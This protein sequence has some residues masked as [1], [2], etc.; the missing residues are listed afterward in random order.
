MKNVNWFEILKKPMLVIGIGMFIMM[1]CYIWAGI[2]GGGFEMPF[3]SE[4]GGIFS[5]LD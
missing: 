1:V 5:I 4:I 2:L 3:L